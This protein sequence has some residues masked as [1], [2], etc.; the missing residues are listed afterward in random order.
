MKVNISVQVDDREAVLRSSR[1]MCS[2]FAKYY[3]PKRRDKTTAIELDFLEQPFKK[4]STRSVKDILHVACRTGRRVVRLARKGY[5]CTGR[6]LTSDAIE[7]AE[8]R[9]QQARINVHLTNE[10]ASKLDSSLSSRFDAVLALYVLFLLPSD[11]DVMSCLKE[12]FRALRRGGVFV[13][14]VLNP[15]RQFALHV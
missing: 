11:E 10:E 2:R 6:D 7:V 14:N 4:T 3:V 1:K 9:A 15:F 12:C 5:N 8:R 13:G